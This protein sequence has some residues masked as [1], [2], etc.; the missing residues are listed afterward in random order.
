MSEY[1]DLRGK[2][3]LL[4]GLTHAILKNLRSGDNVTAKH[5][6]AVLEECYVDFMNRW[7]H[8]VY[9]GKLFGMF[10]SVEAEYILDCIRSMSDIIQSLAIKFLER[11]EL[12]V[13]DVEWL[14][15]YANVILEVQDS[16]TYYI[17]G[18]GR[19]GLLGDEKIVNGSI[20]KILD[21][22]PPTPDNA[23]MKL[24]ELMRKAR[25]LGYSVVIP[26]YPPIIS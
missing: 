20:I 26:I 11:D 21:Y 4:R 2:V 14:E 6:M 16:V 22:T 3:S 15:E 18:L 8:L 25:T 1:H 9:F 24:I 12:S 19:E 17:L 23:V 5:S 10:G 7:H 13:G